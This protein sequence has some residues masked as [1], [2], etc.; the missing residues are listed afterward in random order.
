MNELDQHNRSCATC[1][2]PIVEPY[3]HCGVCDADYC[4][5]C[6]ATHLCTATCRVNGCTPGLCVKVIENGQVAVPWGVPARLPEGD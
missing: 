1:G 4:L 6:G 5:A 2:E 3:A